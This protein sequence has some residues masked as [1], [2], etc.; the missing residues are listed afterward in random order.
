MKNLL[1]SS[2]L[3]LMLALA[4]TQAIASSEIWGQKLDLTIPSLEMPSTLVLD[5]K[6]KQEITMGWT[7]CYHPT[8]LKHVQAENSQKLIEL[9]LKESQNPLQSIQF[10]IKDRPTTTD[11]VLWFGIHALDIHSTT[12]GMRYSCLK[13]GNPLL[14]DRPS[15]K[16][17]ILHKGIILS[18]LHSPRT[19]SNDIKASE[20][21]FANGIIALVVA[22]NY[23]LARKAKQN[24]RSC[25]KIR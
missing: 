14:P 23:R 5:S 21:Q 18:L 8:L 12:K 2:Y 4:S 25:P 24:P 19:S 16:R 13:E 20:L 3:L 7:C 17:L 1:H 22:N 11:W 10:E 6:V 9:R 15:A